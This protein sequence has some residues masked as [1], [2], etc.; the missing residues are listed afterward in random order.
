ML[1]ISLLLL[2][3]AF[4]LTIAAATGKPTLWA[5]VVLVIVA[6]LLTLLPVR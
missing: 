5:A 2:L 4:I 6:Q 3:A 1:T